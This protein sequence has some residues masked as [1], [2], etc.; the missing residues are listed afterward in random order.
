[1]WFKAIFYL[2]PLCSAEWNHLCNFLEGNHEELFVKLYSILT[3]SSISISKEIWFK[4]IS[5]LEP[6]QPSCSDSEWAKPTVQ[7]CEIILNLD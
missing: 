4:D 3:N 2:E 1:M 7:F 6:W 5:Y